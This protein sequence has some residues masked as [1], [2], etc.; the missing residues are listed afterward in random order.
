[1]PV[2]FPFWEDPRSDP[3]G[4][5][6][7]VFHLF[8]AGSAVGYLQ[9]IILW[10]KWALEVTHKKYQAKMSKALWAIKHIS[11][12]HS[13]CHGPRAWKAALFS[14]QVNCRRKVPLSRPHPEL[15]KALIQCL[16]PDHSSQAASDLLGCLWKIISPSVPPCPDPVTAQCHSEG[17]VGYY[18]PERK[19]CAQTKDTR[20]TW[21]HSLLA[22]ELSVSLQTIGL[23][24]VHL[25]QQW[26]FTCF[27]LRKPQTSQYPGT[28]TQ[29]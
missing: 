11:H 15:H 29:G 10:H 14:H 4:L 23:C 21:G 13:I 26:L 5:K 12:L 19:G 24:V 9:P 18:I 27:L 17:V 20:K 28:A 7:K 6:K 16:D 2:H 8:R 25:L 3:L 22:T 1:M